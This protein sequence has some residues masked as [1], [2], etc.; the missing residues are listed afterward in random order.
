[1]YTL[2]L[3]VG[4]GNWLWHYR[5][6]VWISVTAWTVII[7]FLSISQEYCLKFIVKE[8]NYSQIIM[9]K[10]FEK[11]DQPLMV[12][13]IRRRQLPPVRPLSEPQHVDVL[14]SECFTVCATMEAVCPWYWLSVIV[15][16]QSWNGCHFF[17]VY[18]LRKQGSIICFPLS[19][20]SSSQCALFRNLV[21][22]ESGKDKGRKI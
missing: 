5:Y 22:L 14:N 12:E 3:N 13:I 20:F 18:F 10:E 21:C 17:V 11:I 15:S 7:A 16:P 8:S 1:M 4:F 19:W 2:A 9:T 6:V